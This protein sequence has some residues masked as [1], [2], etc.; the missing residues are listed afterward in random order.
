MRKAK[1]C[2]VTGARSEYGLMRWV[3]EEIRASSKLELQVAVTGSHLLPEFGETWRAIEADGLPIHEKVPAP[4][5]TTR[6]AALASTVG[7][8]TRGFAAAFER[9]APDCVLV[10]GDRYELLSVSAAATVM[11]I[12]LAHVSGGEITHGAVD[13]Q[14]RHAV[15][16]LA[17]LHFAAN[18]VYAAR[19]LQMGEEPWRVFTTGEPGLDNARRLTLPSRDELSKELDGFDLSRPSVLVAFHSTT[20]ELAGLDR[21]VAELSAAL[22]ASRL[23]IVF[24][25]PNADAGAEKIIGAW[26]AFVAHRPDCRLFQSLGQ[27]RYLGMM[28]HAAMIVGNS[29]SG[30]VEA[31]TFALPAVNIGARQGGRMRGPNVIDCGH[32]RAEI[33]AAVRRA[34]RFDRSA[35]CENP[36]GDGRSS[37]R[38]RAALEEVLGGKSRADILRK[39][40]T[41]LPGAGP[42]PAR[43]GGEFDIDASILAR[44]RRPLAATLKLGK[45]AA[46]PASGRAALRL[47]LDDAR[48]RGKTVLLPDFLCAEAILPALEAAGARAAFY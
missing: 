44:P 5:D 3:M 9:L 22:E 14:I 45:N 12:P 28:R 39:G 36:Y 19:L 24:T 46:L 33:L 40:F 21:Q 23:P 13:D 25:Y 1:V 29:S 17:H 42:R 26:K 35:P 27:R 34:L 8:W 15:T 6:P 41:D 2:V 47:C 16:K 38:V 4:L 11:G 48:L 37:E 32:G 7:E 10:M 31:P 18:G 30:L 20:Q 43:V